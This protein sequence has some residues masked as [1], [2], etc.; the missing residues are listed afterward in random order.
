MCIFYTNNNYSITNLHK[1]L[2]LYIKSL[3]VPILHIY[4]YNKD[5]IVERKICPKNYQ[6]SQHVKSNIFI[7]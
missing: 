3:V 4:F 5:I 7:S 6:G 2:V 1:S